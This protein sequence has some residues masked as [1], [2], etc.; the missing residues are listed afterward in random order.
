MPKYLNKC[1]NMQ[2]WPDS[3]ERQHLSG[4]SSK[5]PHGEE[6]H[7]Q[8]GAEHHLSCVCGCVSDRKG[9][10]HGPSETWKRKYESVV[11][12]VWNIGVIFL[13]Q[14]WEILFRETSVVLFIWPLPSTHALL[15]TE[16]VQNLNMNKNLTLHYFNNTT[17]YWILFYFHCILNFPKAM[18]M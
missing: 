12:Y 9:E 16:C 10:R 8:R 2:D 1:L 18:E 6:D 11:C 15:V 13:A 14:I 5:Y 7:Q 3:L 17:N 4:A